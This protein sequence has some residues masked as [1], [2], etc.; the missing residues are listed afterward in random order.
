MASSKLSVIKFT[1]RKL[2]HEDGTI[3]CPVGESIKGPASL[4][5]KFNLLTLL[6]Y[7]LNLH[8]IVLTNK[9]SHY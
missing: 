2:G 8:Y 6:T 3:N 9:L 4:K 5:I 1:K 7:T